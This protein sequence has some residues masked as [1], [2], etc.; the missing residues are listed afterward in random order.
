MFRLSFSKT[1]NSIIA[2]Y[3]TTIRFLL[4][5]HYLHICFKADLKNKNLKLAC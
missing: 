1:D 5:N 2:S 4:T 3:Q